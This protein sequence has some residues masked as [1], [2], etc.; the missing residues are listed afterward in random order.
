MK[1]F[2]FEHN[3]QKLWY[4]RSLAV[5]AVVH[6]TDENDQ[7]GYWFSGTEPYSESVPRVFFPA[8]GRRYDYDGSANGRGRGGYY[9]SSSKYGSAYYIGFSNGGSVYMG[10]DGDCA[11]G[12]SVRCLQVTD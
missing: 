8:A 7:T 5:S 10:S 12:F 1:N 11:N 3:G 6:Y 4:S 2:E 9:W